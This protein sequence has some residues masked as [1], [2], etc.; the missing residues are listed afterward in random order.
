MLLRL[1]AEFRRGVQRAAV[2]SS[3]AATANAVL[4]LARFDF[5]LMARGPRRPA[6]FRSE[7]NRCFVELEGLVDALSGN[8]I[9]PPLELI[10]ALDSLIALLVQADANGRPEGHA[11]S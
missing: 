7:C 1:I 4:E 2:P 6:G 9:L 3:L 5:V 11:A 10:H 8:Q